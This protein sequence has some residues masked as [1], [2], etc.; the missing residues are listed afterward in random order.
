MANFETFRAEFK[1][2]LVTPS[3]EGY[4]VSIKRWARNAIK[5]AAIVAYVKDAEDVAR[6]LKYAQDAGLDIAIHSGGHS[7]AGN[8]STDGGL[9]IDLSRHINTVRVD[10]DAKLAYVGG[11][12]KWGAFD[13]ETMKHG[14]AGV[15]GTVHHVRVVA[16][17]PCLR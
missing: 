3:D 5:R 12:A 2:D 15:A 16:F 4:E 8:S 13:R 6:A 10:P 1:G 9:V 14:L 11:G 17:E 7:A